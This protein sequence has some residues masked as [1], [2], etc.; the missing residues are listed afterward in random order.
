MAKVNL[1][2]IGVAKGGT[3][4]LHEIMSKKENL[5]TSSWKEASFFS[6]IYQNCKFTGPGDKDY[7]GSFSVKT[8]ESYE[9]LFKD[10]Q[11]D[12]RVDASPIYFYDISSIQK[13]LNY[14]PN[15]KFIL[16]LRDPIKRAYSNYQMHV[17]DGLEKETFDMAMKLCNE[18]LNS[19]WHWGWDYYGFSLYYENLKK[20]FSIT[21]KNNLLVINFDLLSKNPEIVSNQ[22]NNFLAKN[23]FSKADFSEKFNESGIPKLKF[24]SRFIHR[25]S[26]VRD[27]LM[28]ILGKTGKAM[29]KK[30]YY[31]YL[32]QRSNDLDLNAGV[33]KA[34]EDD[35][36]MSKKIIH[37]K[38][39]VGFN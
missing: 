20:L 37:D 32:M 4:L 15:S 36:K 26:M 39:F 16:V 27:F 33:K 13:I 1:F 19:G 21:D 38:D 34:L 8:I 11:A 14:N 6:E 30:F 18:R 25:K 22:L 23:Y 3:T 7:H 17:R 29:L 12:Y 31:K 5:C 10:Q 24:A 9:S 35:W 2:I 28:N